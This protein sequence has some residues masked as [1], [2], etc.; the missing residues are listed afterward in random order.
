MERNKRNGFI[1]AQKGVKLGDMANIVVVDEQL[2]KK[3]MDAICKDI[4][5]RKQQLV[6]N[7]EEHYI[8]ID[9][10]QG[11]KIAIKKK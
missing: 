11:G 3:K 9:D 2:A 1:T 8:C 7:I 5:E 10:G 4:E 6:R